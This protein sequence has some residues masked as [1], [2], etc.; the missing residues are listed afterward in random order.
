MLL[1]LKARRAGQRTD[2]LER[3]FDSAARWKRVLEADGQSMS[4]R[5]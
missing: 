3:M 2:A 5:Q 1:E 4:G